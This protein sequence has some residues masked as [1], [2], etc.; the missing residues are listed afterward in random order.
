MRTIHILLLILFLLLTF[1]YHTKKEHFDTEREDLINLCFSDPTNPK[2]YTA[3]RT[4]KTTSFI[5]DIDESRLMYTR[6]ISNNQD[7]SVSKCLTLSRTGL[8]PE[9][10]SELCNANI[11]RSLNSS[12]GNS[13][14]SGID[15]LDMPGIQPSTP[16][17]NTLCNNK[18]LEERN[19]ASS[20]PS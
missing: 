2:C 9:L 19:S 12:Y 13:S 1:N 17:C 10:C 4:V 20:G 5:P 7:N 6:C 8:Y 11:P 14:P 16:Y 15:F 18:M 3:Q